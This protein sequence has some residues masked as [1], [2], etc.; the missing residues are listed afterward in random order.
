MY[1]IILS[2]NAVKQLDSLNTTIYLRIYKV[3]E[4]LKV[5]PRPA[6]CLKLTNSESYRIR[7]GN[8]RVIYEIQDDILRVDIYQIVHRKDAYKH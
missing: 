6:G 2:K 3:L 7:V 1:R 8:Y 5:N 4:S